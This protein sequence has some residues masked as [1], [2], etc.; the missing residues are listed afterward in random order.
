MPIKIPLSKTGKYAGQYETIVDDIDSDL[1][2]LNWSVKAP[3]NIKST[4]YAIRQD[5]TTRKT[6]RLHRVVME[7]VLGRKLLKKEQ[8]DHINNNSLD[9]RRENLRVCT[10]RQ[11]QRNR[12][13]YSTNTS[14]Y[15]GVS[16]IKHLN[17]WGARISLKSEYKH[18]GVFDTP[19]D[20]HKAYCEA[21]KEYH[22]EYANYGD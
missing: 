4:K 8:V 21:A 18:L 1:A 11:N 10:N 12:G 13:K 22:G 2:E 14:G 20:A 17:K 5:K 3:R 7:R 6:I 15:K 19:E 16:F 9:N